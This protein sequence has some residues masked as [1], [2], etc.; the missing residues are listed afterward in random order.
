LRLFGL[1]GGVVLEFVTE[2]VR[3]AAAVAQ[4]QNSA[5]AL[6]CSVVHP[7]TG[8]E[9]IVVADQLLSDILTVPEFEQMRLE[10]AFEVSEGL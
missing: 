7:K 6:H 5:T 10:V 1:G 2:F 9:I 8:S 3:V 4:A